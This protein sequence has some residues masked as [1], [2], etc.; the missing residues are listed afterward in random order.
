MEQNDY[1][2]INLK[3]NLSY[4]HLNKLLSEKLIGMELRKGMTVQK[5]KLYHADSHLNMDMDIEGMVDSKVHTEFNLWIDGE[6]IKLKD[7]NVKLDA[8]GILGSGINYV[9]EKW[10][11][12]NLQ[13]KIEEAIHEKLQTILYQ[14]INEE[15]IVPMEQGLQMRLA[16][17]S[18]N[19]AALEALESGIFARIVADV[20]ID[21]SNL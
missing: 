6:N 7:F 13:S 15:K 9:I 3:A 5:I 20:S 16:I 8:L 10:F 19:I 21:V 1:S 4:D 2:K 12:S 17:Q 14:M 18:I 11:K